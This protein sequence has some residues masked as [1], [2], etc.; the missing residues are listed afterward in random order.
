MSRRFSRTEI[1]E[2][3][4]ACVAAG[5][6]I[7]CATAG[8]GL[9]A[10]SLEAGGVDLLLTSV[11]G[12]ARQRGLPSIAWKLNE[13]NRYVREIFEEISD[14]VHDTP[15]V[16]S[17][18]ATNEPVGADY[19]ALTREYAEL[20]Y[21][22][23]LNFPTVGEFFAPRFEQSMAEFISRGGSNGATDFEKQMG[24]AAH[25]HRADLESKI[26]S[27]NGYSRELEMIQAAHQSDI[28]TMGYAWSVSGAVDMVNAGADIIVG[29][30]GGTGGGSAGAALSTH[31]EAAQWLKE[32]F[33]AAKSA[34]PDILLM[35]HGGPFSTPEDTTLLY[36]LTDAVG[37][38][39]GSAVERIPIERAV[40]NA[41][42]EF[43]RVPLGQ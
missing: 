4:R 42:A 9:V 5:K 36:D 34:R 38:L 41:V 29:H 11:T 2:R 35:G 22:G 8:N 37:F 17:I 43:K 33:D 6:P 1:L 27:G 15:L 40:R 20:G 21:S 28:F 3:L 19:A 31:E 32:I 12:L 13:N 30:C 24:Q 39:S 26:T 10:R 25:A 18:G 23:V 7:L 16:V 14:V